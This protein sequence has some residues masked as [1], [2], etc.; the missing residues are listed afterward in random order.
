MDLLLK[1]RP[2]KAW[3]S[4]NCWTSQSNLWKQQRPTTWGLKKTKAK[5][6]LNTE[7]NMNEQISFLNIE[8]TACVRLPPD[9]LQ[10]GNICTESFPHAAENIFFWLTFIIQA[11]FAWGESSCPTLLENPL[12]LLVEFLKPIKRLRII[13]NLQAEKL[14]HPIGKPL[15]PPCGQ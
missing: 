2:S 7:Q 12:P 15:A 8:E 11:V 14:P 5:E 1:G 3:Q 10:L 6:K 9:S 13:I 4:C